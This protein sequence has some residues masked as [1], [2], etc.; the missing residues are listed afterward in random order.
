M[1]KSELDGD[2]ATRWLRNIVLATFDALIDEA[3]RR[4]AA[5]DII[6]PRQSTC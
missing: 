6:K 1:W 3:D 4:L 2:P 5:S